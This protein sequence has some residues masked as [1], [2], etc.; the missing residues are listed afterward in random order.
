MATK[1]KARDDFRN[2]YDKKVIVPKRV[3]EGLKTLGL[4]GWE[5]VREFLRT[6]KIQ[7]RDWGLFSKDY[8][9]LIVEASDKKK[10]ICGSKKLADEFREMV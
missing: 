8:E 5:Y 10:V 2:Q 9:H 4:T 1:I 6:N 7:E 3:Q